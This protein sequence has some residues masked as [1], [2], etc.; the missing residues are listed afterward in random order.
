[1]IQFL[2]E[3]YKVTRAA[4]VLFLLGADK[5]VFQRRLPFTVFKGLGAQPG[6]L[7]GMNLAVFFGVKDMIL[8]LLDH[9]FAA[10]ARDVSSMSPLLWAAS[11]GHSAVVEVLLSLNDCRSGQKGPNDRP[12]A[13]LRY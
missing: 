2:Q 10:D 7:S 6:S 8:M 3:G 11:V 4:Q 1:M 13:P 5:V 12:G 9:G